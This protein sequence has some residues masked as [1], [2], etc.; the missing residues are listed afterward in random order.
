MLIRLALAAVFIVAGAGKLLD[1]PGSRAA[2]VD[3]DVPDHLAGAL[4]LLLPAAELATAVG[5]LFASTAK[6]AGVAALALLCAFVGGLTRALRRGDAP[7][8]HCFGQVHSTPASWLT[9]ARNVGLA[10]PAIYLA[11]DGPGPSLGSWFRGHSAEDLWLIATSSVAVISA[12]CAAV[13]WRQNKRLQIAGPE[14]PAVALRVGGRA[15]AFTLPSVGGPLVSLQ[16][17]LVDD[18]PCLLTFVAQGCGPCAALLPEIARW[19]DALGDRL[20]LPIVSVGAT[21]LAEELVRQYDLVQVLA[22]AEAKVSLAYGIEGTPSAVLVGSDGSVK[23]APAAGEP[24][25][26]ALVR[27]ALQESPRKPV[28]VHKVVA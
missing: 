7:D 15:P 10:I 3:F 16:E 8:C 28:V 14:T 1:R 4:V 2:L 13:L 17:L 25:I 18:R 26:E 12:A 6:W 23:S 19:H 5:L 27:L 24:A 20:A 22:D 11:A 21:S 9:V